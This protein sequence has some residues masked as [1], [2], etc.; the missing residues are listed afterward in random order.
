MA[1]SAAF[2]PIRSARLRFVE[3]GAFSQRSAR[4]D[5]SGGFGVAASH[6]ICRT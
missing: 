4:L 3:A 5:P 2:F 6:A 1:F